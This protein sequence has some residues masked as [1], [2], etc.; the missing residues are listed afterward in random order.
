MKTG[1]VAPSCHKS[2]LCLSLFVFFVTEGVSQAEPDPEA[3]YQHQEVSKDIV[4][5]E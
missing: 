1:R 4:E 3:D 2:C 5:V